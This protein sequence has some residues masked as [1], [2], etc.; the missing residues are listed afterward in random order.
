MGLCRRW[1]SNPHSQEGNWILSPARLPV[2]PQRQLIQSSHQGRL[3]G[4]EPTHAGTT[5]RCVNQLHH[6]RHGR[7]RGSRTPTDGFGDRC[8]TIKLYPYEMT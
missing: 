3:M 1:E 7:G 6:N 4:F 5:N 2:P 8:S